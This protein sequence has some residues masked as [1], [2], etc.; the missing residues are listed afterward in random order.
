MNL[1]EPYVSHVLFL[2][3]LINGWERERLKP[4]ELVIVVV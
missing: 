2:F 4:K 3:S 1:F